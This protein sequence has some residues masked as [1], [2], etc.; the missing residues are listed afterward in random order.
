MIDFL[1]PRPDTDQ[2]REISRKKLGLFPND[3]A[4]I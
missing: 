4:G 3:P 2:T 1:I